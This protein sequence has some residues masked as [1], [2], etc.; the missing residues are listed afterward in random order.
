MHTHTI[1]F[2]KKKKKINYFIFQ[3]N[4]NLNKEHFSKRYVSVLM[5]EILWIILLFLVSWM[6]SYSSAIGK[7]S[8][9]TEISFDSFKY[10][11]KINL[12]FYSLIFSIFAYLNIGRCTQLFP[13]STL[14]LRQ[15][16]QV[17]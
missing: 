9:D 14:D 6:P 5:L 12:T 8:G 13:L 17:L 16:K 10:C 7:S 4:H 15:P 1:L 2:Y 11:S 3:V